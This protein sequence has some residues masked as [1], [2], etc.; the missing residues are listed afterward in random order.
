M[1]LTTITTVSCTL[2][3]VAIY[4]TPFNTADRPE[5]HLHNFGNGEYPGW[6]HRA[7]VMARKVTT[8]NIVHIGIAS[9]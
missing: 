6:K 4:T 5:K 3:D 2:I 7:A 8:A 1:P 9:P